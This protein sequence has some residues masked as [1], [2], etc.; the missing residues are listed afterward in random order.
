[1]LFAAAGQR[2]TVGDLAGATALYR[3]L[4]T[5]APHHVAARNNLANALAARGCRAEALAEA[6]AA[7]ADVAPTDELAPA[8]RDT[9][10]ELEA[11]GSAAPA[12]SCR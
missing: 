8:V 1:M 9:L 5:T 11:A 12:A 4:L 10:A 2:H 6:R 7:L 3:Q